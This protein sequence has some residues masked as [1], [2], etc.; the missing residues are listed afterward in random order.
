M[1][2]GFAL[3]ISVKISAFSFVSVKMIGLY[4]FGVIAFMTTV[5]KWAVRP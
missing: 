2:N 3:L 4:G 1:C 5:A